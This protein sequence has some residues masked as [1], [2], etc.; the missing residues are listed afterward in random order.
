LL[1][2]FSSAAQLLGLLA[3]SLGG[4]WWTRRR[5]P[6][7]NGAAPASRTPFVVALLLLVTVSVSFAL[8]H[9]RVVDANN[10]RL[11][12]NL[13]RSSTEAGKKVGD[14]SLKTLAY[15]DQEQH[16]LGVTTEQLAQWL[17][18]DHALNLV[19][20]REDEEV[21]MGGIAGTWHRRYPD[22][23]AQE[24]GLLVD[25]R[26]TILLCESGNR[27]SELSHYF[28]EQGIPTKFMVGGYEKW[29]AEGRPVE[30]AD[31]RQRDD[32]RALP[33]F[34]NKHAL[35]DTD[36]V[37]RLYTDENA[38]FVDVR[39]PGDFELGHL[40][41]AVNVPLRKMTSPEM[42]AALEALPKRPIV[43]P[44]YDKR[45]SFYALI[46]GV[47]LSRMGHDFRG[48][49]TVPHEF[50]LPKRDSAWVARWK[51]DNA[52]RTLF[53]AARNQVGAVLTFCREQLGSLL[54][55]IVVLSLL[56]RLLLLPLTVKA[57]RDGVVQ[58]RS[59]PL[60][61]ALRGE[62]A[63]DGE[64]LQRALRARLRADRITPLRN[65]AGSLATLLL[66]TLLFAAI[67][68]ASAASTEHVLW[69]AL[70]TPDPFYVLPA[71]AGVLLA[72]VAWLGANGNRR[73][74]KAGLVFAVV[75]T[76]LVVACRAGTQVYLI[77]SFLLLLA[78]SLLVRR[79][80]RPATST[81]PPAL[82]PGAIVPLRLAGQHPELGGKAVRLGQMIVAGFPVPDGFAIADGPVDA[83][84]LQAACTGL[85]NVPVAVRSSARGEDGEQHSFAGS[86]HTELQVQAHDL[87]RA[88]DKVRDSYGGRGG[89]VVVQAMVPAD[90]AGVM[91]TED[92]AHSGR[93]LVEMVDG[94]G[95]GL[96]SGAVIPTEHRF[97]RVTGERI[98]PASPGPDLQRLITFGRQLEAH[99][100]HPQDVE[101]AHANG[102]FLLLQSRNITSRAGHGDDPVAV[103]E[104]ER[105]RL[106]AAVAGE[107]ADR[108][109]FV[110]GDYASLLPQPTEL[111]LELMQSIWAPGGTVDLACRRLGL[112]FLAGE[113][114]V[115][116]V[117][118]VFGHC[119]AD[120]R[121]SHRIHTPA[122]AAFR[123][124]LRSP[125]LE[126]RF[127]HDFLPPFLRAA[128]L[129]SVMALER[130]SLPA[131]QELRRETWRA[132]L[133]GSYLEAEV[134]NLAAEAYVSSARR[135][136][137]HKGLD[138]AALLAFDTHTV[139]R[140]A[141]AS[142]HEADGAD[143]FLAA[144]GHRAPHDFELSEPRYGERPAMVANMA[145]VAAAA[146]TR[147]NGSLA[148][149]AMRGVLRTELARAR[150]FTEL[151]EL[152]KHA[153][154]HDLALLRR[155]LLAIG[156]RTGLGDLVFDLRTGELDRIDDGDL[157]AVRPIAERR[158]RDRA[159]LVE[160][161]PPAEITPAALQRL[162]EQ[163]PLPSLAPHGLR[164]LRVA[165][166]HDVSGTV[167][168]LR[169]A[170]HIDRLGPDDVLVV[171]CTDPGWMPAFHRVCGLVSEVGGWLSHA[172]IQAREHNLPTIV[173]VA[174]ATTQLRDGDRVR[175]RRDGSIERLHS[176]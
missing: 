21:E 151:K 127:E 70:G 54:L 86:F 175:L 65:F 55:A 30:G 90:H 5:L 129:R 173:G 24:K 162:G 147:K 159:W 16:P 20:V 91:F 119:Y 73:G 75:I 79:W 63:H 15:S 99:F 26:E 140:D 84:A 47:R 172:S 131:L 36:E 74:Q 161:A 35:L 176:A 64:R 123:L 83:R 121:A 128:R 17:A 141:F 150:R 125:E 109:V 157:A 171:R 133:T 139:V 56:L 43:A 115:P 88:V 59:K 117:R 132:F 33:E 89:G 167:R 103:R 112:G 145:T 62:L 41:D 144:F 114:D 23:Q 13:V 104:A 37:M 49:Y 12:A 93:C 4:G 44:C 122:R 85:G 153:A 19:D 146:S 142:L 158:R 76:A 170:E 137:Q 100:G 2:L 124:G 169:S 1:N 130:L 107:P 116:A 118:A 120:V 102:R 53:G 148:A 22:L 10:R 87:V 71:I 134:V 160:V 149:P 105:A 68:R 51:A 48:R 32:L 135:R 31:H 67:D 98:G 77:T 69:F 81:P 136:L 72:G 97:G 143:R 138:A 3:L 45:S 28:R 94:L 25:D 163:Q 7:A 111:S 101:W 34:P 58:A 168:V 46:L 108:P 27:S 78:Q 50:S 60:A 39:Y 42:L 96:V 8:Y 152:A 166:D 155:V 156:E 95:E 29:T 92:P 164:G 165:G 11:H 113:H 38:L 66:F 18:A 154:A 9:F 61:A 57:D 52:E 126:R 6:T 174:D 14:A 106:L 82:A 40:P 80:L 110:A